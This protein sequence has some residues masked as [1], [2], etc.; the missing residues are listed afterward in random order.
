MTQDIKHN[1][2][3]Y[4]K[5]KTSITEK[6]DHLTQFTHSN[7]RQLLITPYNEEFGPIRWT[8][9]FSQLLEDK[10]FEEQMEFYAITESRRI[11][12]MAYGEITR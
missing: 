1:D 6:E 3:H 10:S 7:G 4:S 11:A 8:E 9:N 12:S 5:F 2:L